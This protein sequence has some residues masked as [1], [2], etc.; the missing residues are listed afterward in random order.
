MLMTFIESVCW[1]W[2]DL[3]CLKGVE[4]LGQ[5]LARVH[6]LT[7]HPD[8]QPTQFQ[9]LARAQFEWAVRRTPHCRPEAQSL[10]RQVEALAP[11]LRETRSAVINHGDLQLSNLLGSKPLL[12]D[13]EYAQLADPSYDLACLLRYYPALEP[14]TQTLLSAAELPGPAN[15]D[16]LNLNLALFDGLNRLWTLANTG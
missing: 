3:N 6:A 1:E 14:Y 12:I 10:I 7:P 11:Q 5:C 16:R 8:L 9:R 15:R 2:S 4:T 13:W